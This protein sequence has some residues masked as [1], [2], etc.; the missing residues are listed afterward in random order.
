[1]KEKTHYLKNGYKF[2]VQQVGNISSLIIVNTN[3]YPDDD[4]RMDPLMRE[5]F[6]PINNKDDLK[7][8]K[9]LFK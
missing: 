7:S 1:M 5:I 2:T 3:L 4:S 6:I 8:I 9:K